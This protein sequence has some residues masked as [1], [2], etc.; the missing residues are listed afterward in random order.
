MRTGDPPAPQKTGCG[1]IPSRYRTACRRRLAW[2]QMVFT[3]FSR[4]S[5]KWQTGFT[6]CFRFPEP[7]WQRAAEN[8][9][10]GRASPEM[11]WLPQPASVS[12]GLQPPPAPHVPV[13]GPGRRA[14]AGPVHPP[15]T[16]PPRLPGGGGG[17][18]PGND[19]GGGRMKTS[20]VSGCPQK[21]GRWPTSA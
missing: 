3:I 20:T 21:A 4:H 17:P 14:A 2:P 18:A 7:D 1:A 9:N 13:S 11:I 19:P 8:C 5:A 10:T 12:R 15:D 16:A 6:G